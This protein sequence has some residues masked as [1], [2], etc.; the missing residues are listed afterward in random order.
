M[1]RRKHLDY[2]MESAKNNRDNFD[3]Y[4]NRLKEL[5]TS[6]FE[7]KRMPLSIDTRFLEIKLFENGKALFFED[8]ILGYLTL[9]F[10]DGGKL[11]VYGNPIDRRAYANNGYQINK[12]IVDSV[13]IYDNYMHKSIYRDIKLFAKKL[14]LIDSVISINVNA[15]KTPILITASEKERL[16]MINLYKEYDG[17][18]PVIFGDTNLNADGVKVLNTQ[19]PYVSR[20]LYE[21]KVNIW[22]EALTYL[23]ISNVN[24]TKRERLITDEVTR[25][26]GGTVA[27]RYS[28]LESRR[29][30][31]KEINR[32]FGLNL[33]VDYREDLQIDDEFLADWNGGTS[34]GGEDDE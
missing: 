28:R 32:M 11:D 34:D 4:F 26:Q 7:Y 17:N 31:C 1:R 2:F 14:W 30:A 9:P 33:S 22:N 29:Q 18:S 24:I 12:N 13:I 20:D 16:T 25:N 27:S 15:Q 21:L 19:A 6:R 5:A 23:G 3:Y 8:D 10:A